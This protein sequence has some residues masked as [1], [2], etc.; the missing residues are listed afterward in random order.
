MMHT[1][2]AEQEHENFFSEL[3]Y[4]PAAGLRCNIRVNQGSVKEYV[5]GQQHV[6]EVW[7]QELLNRC[8]IE[9]ILLKQDTLTIGEAFFI[10]SAL[11]RI[12]PEILA[13][14]LKKKVRSG[15]TPYILSPCAYEKIFFHTRMALC[16]GSNVVP[17]FTPQYTKKLS[18]IC[19]ETTKIRETKTTSASYHYVDG[20]WR[21]QR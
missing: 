4:A 14:Q 5:S 8:I 11:P 3:R 13:V 15:K 16:Y 2:D 9:E 6:F 17:L 12:L 21:K 10:T 18:A 1:K 20:K 7:Q 19:I